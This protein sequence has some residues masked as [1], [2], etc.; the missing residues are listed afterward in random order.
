[1]KKGFP[2]KAQASWNPH[3]WAVSDGLKQ[4]KVEAWKVMTWINMYLN[5]VKQVELMKAVRF[6]AMAEFLRVQ[7]AARKWFKKLR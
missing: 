5:N 2:L 4:N 1:M 6:S 3:S 7:Y